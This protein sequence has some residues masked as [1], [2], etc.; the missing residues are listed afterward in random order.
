MDERSYGET[1][2]LQVS[3]VSILG[4]GI[5]GLSAGYYLKQGG[6]P[7]TIYEAKPYVGGN[8]VTYEWG[9][10]RFDSGPHRFHAKDAEI[11]SFVKSLLSGNL[12]ETFAPNQVYYDSKFLK[13]PFSPLNLAR[14]M[15]LVEFL[16]ASFQY[17]RGRRLR[18]SIQDLESY[19]IRTYG[20]SIAERFLLNYS[21]KLWGVPARRLSA[22]LARSRLKGLGV[23]SLIVEAFG[24]RS[25]HADHLEGKFYYPR[26]G[27]GRIADAL[28]SHCG[29]SN[30]RTH[31]RV[32]Q[33]THSNRRIESIVVSGKETPV[34]GVICT[35]P[36]PDMLRMM[37]PPPPERILDLARSLRFRSI[38]LVAIFLKTEQITPNATVYFPTREF[39]FTRIHEP[40]NRCATMAPSGHTSLVA[41]VP[42]G[43]QS[44]MERSTSSAQIA[45]QVIASLARIGLV[46]R[47]SVVG[48]KVVRV[49][50][51]YPVILTETPNAREEILSYLSQ[52]RNLRIVGRCATFTYASIHHLL[53][54]SKQVV[55]SLVEG[56]T[57][58][59]KLLSRDVH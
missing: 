3:H 33:I 27:I 36:L 46:D 14:H 23:R 4:G 17:L 38:L 13:F 40:C 12:H 25:T 54:E 50:N 55:R 7:F 19:A 11:T 43:N 51:A 29:A 21:H 47:R 39:I 49:E 53:R 30:V 56:K 45:E 5:A 16:R 10:F 41:E 24:G 6:V 32:S 35:L 44:E 18:Q 28:V 31:T 15:G 37:E 2:D 57:L 22:T 42:I 1:Q 58:L 26:G 52:F 48:T 59:A 34:S 9:G 8:C 20:R